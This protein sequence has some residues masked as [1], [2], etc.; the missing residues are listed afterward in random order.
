MKETILLI[1]LILL[2]ACQS[3]SKSENA[4]SKARKET[5]IE[6]LE[7]KESLQ[8]VISFLKWYKA[9]YKEVNSFE[10][11]NYEGSL[12]DST[13]Y[14]S[15]NFDETDKYLEKLE[16]SKLL[17]IEYIKTWQ[18]YFMQCGQNFQENPQ[19]DGPPVGF[20]YDLVLLTQEIE[21]TLYS[22]ETPKVINVSE[23]SKKSIVN[24][25]ITMELSF[26]LSK[27]NGIWLIDKIEY[28]SQ[29]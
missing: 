17:S 23:T 11:V 24:V 3:K 2:I 18:S 25:N 21:E 12:N 13:K 29:R 7:T 22:I 4:E 6:T 8:T 9:N 20:D 16:S 14:Y 27:I 1:S 26:S 10:L 15:V 5:S 28:Y 19:N